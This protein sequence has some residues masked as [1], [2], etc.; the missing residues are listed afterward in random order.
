MESNGSDGWDGL[1]ATIA[2]PEEEKKP[3]DAVLVKTEPRNVAVQPE[4]RKG[5]G[6]KVSRREFLKMLGKG[7]A[8]AATAALLNG[9]TGRITQNRIYTETPIGPDR[10]KE[11]D[12]AKRISNAVNTY[13]DELGMKGGSNN[14]REYKNAEAVT[15]FGL[16]MS[17][18]DRPETPQGYP[19]SKS[20]LEY[21]IFGSRKQAEDRAQGMEWLP[22]SKLAHFIYETKNINL[23]TT[24]GPDLLTTPNEELAAEIFRTRY[25][26]HRVESGLLIDAKE[27]AAAEVFGRIAAAK[28]AERNPELV[29]KSKAIQ[30]RETFKTF[31]KYVMLQLFPNNPENFEA[32]KSLQGQ[33][34]QQ[35]GVLP[36][37]RKNNLAGDL[38]MAKMIFLQRYEVQGW[39][40][41]DLNGRTDLNNLVKEHNALT[42]NGFVAPY[43]VW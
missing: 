20:G 2:G 15:Y 17:K 6:K 8:L 29:D 31:V 19:D 21:E 5:R 41:S 27:F 22:W 28:I 12:R 26:R 39:V 11:V 13:A 7:A 9:E 35:V 1:V 32:L 23:R 3:V 42:A 14:F 43:D 37:N 38:T 36:E 34:D 40:E 16:Y 18:K 24:L 25:I 30:Q 4:Q 33:Y 10:Q